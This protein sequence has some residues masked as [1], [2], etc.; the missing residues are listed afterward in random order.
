LL[1]FAATNKQNLIIGDLIMKIKNLLSEYKRI[2]KEMKEEAKNYNYLSLAVRSS[3]SKET[4]TKY[5]NSWKRLISLNEKAY[6]IMYEYRKLCGSLSYRVLFFFGILPKQ[7]TFRFIDGRKTQFK[8]DQM[9]NLL[10]LR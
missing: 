6:S 8:Y 2:A 5:Q 9:I 4:F 1:T 10:N 7:N 3:H